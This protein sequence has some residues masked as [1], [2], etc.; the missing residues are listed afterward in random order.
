MNKYEAFKIIRESGMR[1]LRIDEGGADSYQYDSAYSI[2][3]LTKGH[4]EAPEGYDT[5]NSIY[6]KIVA[7]WRA[8]GYIDNNDDFPFWRDYVN[9]YTAPTDPHAVVKK[10]W[11]RVAEYM[12]E[13]DNK[14]CS[15]AQIKRDI[16][17]DGHSS[18]FSTMRRDEFLEEISPTKVVLSDWAIDKYEAAKKHAE[19]DR[20][21]LEAKLIKKYGTLEDQ[22]KVWEDRIN[23]IKQAFE[24]FVRN[25]KKK[26]VHRYFSKRRNSD[27]V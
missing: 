12:M 16:G 20:A 24:E 8:A 7:E 22:L 18:T 2:Q 10:L 11:Y 3:A 26:K 13:R 17:L 15:A 23:E 6:D 27:D 4:E 25:K 9:V 19:A 5:T 21:K 1:L 14:P